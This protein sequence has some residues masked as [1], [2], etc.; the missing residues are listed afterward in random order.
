MF[1]AKCNLTYSGGKFCPTC[2]TTLIAPPAA[3]PVAQPTVVSQVPIDPNVVG[4]QGAPQI[5]GAQPAN[6]YAQPT[7]VAPKKAINKPLV[8]GLG[9]AGLV[10]AV[11]LSAVAV[12][13]KQA[14][15]AAAA[16]SSSSAAASLALDSE[17]SDALDACSIDTSS[18]GVDQTDARNVT[19]DNSSWSDLYS[20]DIK[21]V[22][23]QLGA[24]ESIIYKVFESASSSGVETF[25]DAEAVWDYSDST[26]TVSITI[27]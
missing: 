4:Q 24:S 11:V 18:L 26:W 3:A 22:M 7:Y 16:A 8:F 15:D 19:L 27:A 20:T 6:F 17:I 5:G 9:A 2:G 10:L 21:C 12:Q 25:G 13:S 23:R 1:C 14:A